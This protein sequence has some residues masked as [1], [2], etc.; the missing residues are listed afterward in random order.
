MSMMFDAS[1][2]HFGFRC[3][4]RFMMKWFHT[5]MRCWVGRMRRV[6]LYYIRTVTD[7]MR[8]FFLMPGSLL[9]CLFVH[10]GSKLS[11]RHRP[12]RTTSIHLRCR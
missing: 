10:D 9:R 3:N 8:I 12:I 5:R 1:R 6:F 4:R 7:A 11:N 2:V